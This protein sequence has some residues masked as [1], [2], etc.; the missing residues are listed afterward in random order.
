MLDNILFIL[1]IIKFDKSF[2]PD[3]ATEASSNAPTT[4]NSCVFW[5]L[6]SLKHFIELNL[7]IF[8]PI[9]IVYM[10]NRC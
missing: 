7:A 2:S 5:E 3:I 4:N 10:Q 1:S 6:I 8:S 9:R